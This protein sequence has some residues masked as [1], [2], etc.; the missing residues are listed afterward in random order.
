MTEEKK[1]VVVEEEKK[2]A[3]AQP[4]APEESARVKELREYLNRLAQNK[5]QLGNQL[6]QVEKE[7]LVTQGMIRE[8]V[9][10]ENEAKKEV[11]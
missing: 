9:T 3:P 5:Q 10:V 2:E 8:R 11:V 7:I 4:V 1:D 6:N